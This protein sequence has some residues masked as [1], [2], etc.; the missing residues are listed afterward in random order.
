MPIGYWLV[1]LGLRIDPDDPKP[2]DLHFWVS[3][4]TKLDV[5][6]HGTGSVQ[7]SV[8]LWHIWKWRSK[9]H[10]ADLDRL[11]LLT[12]SPHAN[13]ASVPRPLYCT[14][15]DWSYHHGDF[16]VGRAMPVHCSS[17]EIIEAMAIFEA[18]KH[19]ED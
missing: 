8:T 3:E 19:N 1:V 4:W 2:N 6:N 7:G 5:Q 10:L 16:I 15:F 14:S 11:L 9:G 17:P 13:H 18:L 12:R